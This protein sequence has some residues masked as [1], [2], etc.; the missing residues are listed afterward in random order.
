MQ[1]YWMQMT[2]TDTVLDLRDTPV[3]RPGSGQLR[4]RM[5]AAALNRGEFVRG[6]WPAR[7][8]RNTGRPLAEKAPVKST[9]SVTASLP[10]GRATASWAGVPAHLQNTH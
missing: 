10:S 6:P 3:P 1:S 9:R 2:D 7:Q 8:G 5:H 4:V